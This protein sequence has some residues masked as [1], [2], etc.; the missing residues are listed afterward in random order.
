MIR[1][2]CVQILRGYSLW[3]IVFSNL[4]NFYKSD[5]WPNVSQ[6]QIL[7]KQNE[8]AEWLPDG[9][10]VEVRT[11]KSGAHRGAEYKVLNKL[12]EV[13]NWILLCLR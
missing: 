12:L 7:A 5:T 10:N 1:S 2:K 13:M 4:P 11:R 8:C 9:W 6:F 3:D